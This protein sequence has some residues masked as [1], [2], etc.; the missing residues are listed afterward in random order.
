MK[1]E[2]DMKN[3]T[4]ALKGLI[5]LTVSMGVVLLGTPRNVF[6]HGKEL[7]KKAGGPARVEVGPHG[8]AVIDIGDGHF[9]LA[10]DPEGNLSLYRLDD[11]LKTIPAEDVDAAQLYALTPGGQTVKFMKAVPSASAP[12][13]FA[14]NPNIT[15][16]G[17]YLAII[18]VS[19]GNESRNLRFQVT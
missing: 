3:M 16:R 18:T 13:H 2:V 12:L 4:C 19:M 7:E 1:T 9:E 10:R 15:Q 8:G 17:G 14:V 11:D 5:L 6:A